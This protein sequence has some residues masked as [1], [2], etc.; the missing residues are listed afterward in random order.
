MVTRNLFAS[1]APAM[2]APA[3]HQAI[4]ALLDDEVRAAFGFPKP[5][6]IIRSL[7]RGVLKVRARVIR[8][9]HPDANPSSS[10]TMRI[11]P[12]RTGTRSVSLVRRD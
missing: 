8:R 11:A 3:V 5:S 12:I 7:V 4:D 6:L 2:F 9:S 1:W 10:P